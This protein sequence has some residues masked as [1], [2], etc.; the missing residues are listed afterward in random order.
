MTGFPGLRVLIGGP[1]E[2]IPGFLRLADDDSA[3]VRYRAGD[4]FPFTDRAVDTI[5]CGMPIAAAPPLLRVPFLL[6]CRRILR[7]GG[8]VRLCIS[9]SSEGEWRRLVRLVGLDEGATRR[10]ALPPAT[11]GRTVVDAAKRDRAAPDEPLVSILIPAFNPRFFAAALDSALAQSWRNL[12]I[13]IGDDSPGPEI[14]TIARARSGAVPIRYERNPV[15]LR[16]RGNSIRCFERARGEFIKFLNDD[17]LLAPEC[18]AALLAP[19][20]ADTDITLATSSRAR[21]DEA[22]RALPDQPATLP[23][24]GETRV[25]AGYSL[26]NTMI[27]AGLN[28]VG[29]PSTA[30][31]RKYDLVDQAPGYFRFDD[32]EGLGIID[33]VTW[34]AL[35][36]RGDAV[37]FHDRL[38]SFRIHT[39][40]RQLAP[41]AGDRA[42]GSIRRLQAAWLPLGVFDILPPDLLLTK[43]YPPRD[44]DEWR[45]ECVLSFLPKSMAPET[46]RA[47]WRAERAASPR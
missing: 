13:V 16:S 10:A 2:A 18:V 40:Q 34:A 35:L 25:V 28:V 47:T 1:D 23:I 45:L 11:D 33:M 30:L 4:E 31:F 5:V 27:G 41:S 14:E 6:E 8:T 37:Y 3:D 21:I 26:A 19:L 44:E 43:P 17:D 38:S 12:E 7:S 24:L 36:L 15:R 22:G 9:A 46:R 29:E 20:C 42:I 32:V 39:A